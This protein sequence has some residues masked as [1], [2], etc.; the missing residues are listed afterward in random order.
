MQV[1]MLD[2]AAMSAFITDLE[3][4]NPNDALE[5]RKTRIHGGREE[6]L[7]AINMGYTLADIRP[8]N[9]ILT[10]ALEP[11]GNND[12]AGDDNVDAGG[13]ARVVP[14]VEPGAGVMLDDALMANN[15]AAMA[16]AGTLNAARD[17]ASA[18]LCSYVANTSIA[19][20]SCDD[21][22]AAWVCTHDDFMLGLV[23]TV[24]LSTIALW[25]CKCRCVLA[26][27][28]R[29][30]LSSA[31]PNIGCSEKR[32]Q[33]HGPGSASRRHARRTDGPGRTSRHE[34]C[35]PRQCPVLR[36]CPARWRCV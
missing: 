4:D 10:D 12:D 5:T 13:I 7:S 6:D 23:R 16:A 2:D 33:P 1:V 27:K 24:L 34:R 17:G 35:Q 26:C 11:P 19:Q 18:C 9:A 15:E 22:C 32:K 28:Q 31:E 25:Q 20:I 36:R 14:Q 30:G 3:A 8:V 21:T 29:D